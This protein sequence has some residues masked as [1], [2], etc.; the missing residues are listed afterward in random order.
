MKIAGIDPGTHRIGFA[1]VEDA[2]RNPVLSH[3]ELIEFPASGGSSHEG[4]L[5]ALAREIE[6]RLVRFRP[7]AVCVEK[8]FFSKNVKTALAVAEARGLILA[9]ASRHAPAVWEIGPAEVKLAVTGYGGAK[10]ADIARM[11][12]MLFP[13][14]LLPKSDDALDAVAIALAGLYTRARLPHNPTNGRG[15]SA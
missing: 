8:I 6:D 11:V 9:A 7:D 15:P 14:S 10:K 4:R 13:R 12:Q 2:P 1:L 3:I 5:A